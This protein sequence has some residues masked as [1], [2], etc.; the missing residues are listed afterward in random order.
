VVRGFVV[1]VVFSLLPGVQSTFAQPRIAPPDA[2][3]ATHLIATDPVVFA[4]L[5]RV[6][7]GS[8]LFRRALQDLQ[9]T[10]RRI[11]IVTD[12]TIGGIDTPG[13]ETSHGLDGSDLAETTPVVDAT[14]RVRAVVV[15]VNVRLLE[16]V[17]ASKGSMLG[18]LQSDIDRILVHEVYGHAM[19]YAIAGDLSGRCP[20]PWPGQKAADACSIRRENE[21]RAQLRLGRRSDA[22]LEGL[23]LSRRLR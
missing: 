16:Q 12:R 19:P 2:A 6:A 23:T 10:D 9:S 17:H 20:D 22:G 13:N 15:F 8:A 1:F 5:E 7:Q 18:E 14:S 11:V 3:T 4:S 21:V